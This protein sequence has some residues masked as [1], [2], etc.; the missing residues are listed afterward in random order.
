MKFFFV[1][2]FWEGNFANYI[3]AAFE[4]NGV[5]THTVNIPAFNHWSK[6]LKLHQLS[7]V[8]TYVDNKRL[9]DSN[10]KVIETIN[11]VK[12]DLLFSFNNSRLFPETV[13]TIR[14]KFHCKTVCLV[15]DNP[16]DSS[17]NKHFALTLPYFDLILV[18]EKMWIPNIRHM[19]PDSRIEF[20]LGAFDPEIFKPIDQ[21]S[22]SE[23]ERIQLGCDISFTGSAYGEQAEGNYRAGIL[24]SLSGYNVKIW[25]DQGWKYREKYYPSLG[26]AYQGGRLS[27]DLLLKLFTISKINL[28][29]PSPQVLTAFQPRVFEIAATKGFQILDYREDLF[30]CY[31]DDE[32]VTFQTIP[33]LKEKIN[34]FLENPEERKR[35]AEKM[36]AKTINYHTWEQRVKEYMSIIR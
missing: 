35:I 11:Q 18:G 9:A 34:Y 32:I 16:F 10:K 28:N 26:T 8:R 4:K 30:Q 3:A 19:A 27:Y 17:R 31:K 23:A 12:P 2:Y 21:N 7:S 33:E 14:D 25:G 22:I 1:N 6:K 20:T 13:K 24:G 15:A 5:S 36:Y 29:M